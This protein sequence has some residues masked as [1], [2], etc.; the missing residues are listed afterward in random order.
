MLDATGDHPKKRMNPRALQIGEPRTPF[1][2][3]LIEFC[4][5][6]PPL[7]LDLTAGNRQVA[8]GAIRGNPF[9]RESESSPDRILMNETQVFGNESDR[10]PLLA[11]PSQLRVMDIAARAAAEYRLRKKR[12]TP[13]GNQTTRVEITRVQ[14]PESHSVLAAAPPARR[15]TLPPTYGYEHRGNRS[16]IPDSL[17]GDVGH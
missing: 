16:P 15:F 17:G 1:R 4:H 10:R 7:E 11:K 8:G 6:M 12:F 2:V 9:G 14:A 3:A 5:Q 13:Q